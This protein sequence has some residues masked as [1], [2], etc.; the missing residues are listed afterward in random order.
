MR[1]TIWLYAA[2]AYAVMCSTICLFAATAYAHALSSNDLPTPAG[3]ASVWCP[4]GMAA[5]EVDPPLVVSMADSSDFEAGS[6]GA[7]IAHSNSD[8][9]PELVHNSILKPG[10]F[11]LARN[12]PSGE[13]G[14]LAQGRSPALESFSLV[15]AKDSVWESSL[16]ESR[17][18]TNANGL[19]AEPLLEISYAGWHLPVSLYNSP[20]R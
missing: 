9:P 15:E 1:S 7:S 20:P 4:P 5:S 2:T 8:R 13:F 10:R 14:S 16:P 3:V 19:S 17:S 12:E 11:G 18:L 6:L